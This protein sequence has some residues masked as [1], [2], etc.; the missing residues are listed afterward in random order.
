MRLLLTVLLTGHALAQTPQVGGVAGGLIYDPP[1]HSLRMLRGV[2]GAAYLGPE[3]IGDID[4]AFVSPD[5]NV[6]VSRRGERI[7][8]HR[9]TSREPQGQRVLTQGED[10]NQQC[11]VGWSADSKTLALA[12]PLSGGTR[13]RSIRIENPAMSWQTDV[14]G[15]PLFIGV[16][17]L[18]GTVVIGL[19]AEQSGVY[20]VTE[21]GLGSAIA[22]FRGI[23]AGYVETRSNTAYVIES[24]TGTLYRLPLRSS[25]S[26]EPRWQLRPEWLGSV[27]GMAASGER[28]ALAERSMPAVHVIDVSRMT[29]TQTVPL[30]ASPQTLL[31]A[32]A[33][34]LWVLN[35]RQSDE[36]GST[37]VFDMASGSAYF[38]P[39][40]GDH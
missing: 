1:T 27:A 6:A 7:Q 21:D 23:E 13:V 37:L 39:A 33:V 20:F 32:G 16:N 2:L 24:E 36:G 26:P 14:P 11:R 28:V 4:A 34:N 25:S 35:S 3:L 5:G 22:S 30:D 19:N 40:R 31:A 15:A 8:I 38:V 17:A 12:C 18:G 9:F 10:L 29:E